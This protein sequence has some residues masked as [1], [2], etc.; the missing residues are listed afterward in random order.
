MNELS[1]KEKNRICAISSNLKGIDE[2]VFWSFRY[3]LGRR[4]IATHCFARGLV[5]AFPDLTENVQNL[6]KKE[7][8]EAFKRDDEMRLGEKRLKSYY[9]LGG[10]HDRESWELVRKVYK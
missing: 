1:Q 8:E 10:N 6:I 5:I 4:T 3:F 9:P 2:L 7:L